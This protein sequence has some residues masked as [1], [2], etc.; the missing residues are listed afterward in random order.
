MEKLF[1]YQVCQFLP[2]KKIFK[3]GLLK[4]FVREVSAYVCVHPWGKL[5]MWSE[6]VLAN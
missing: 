4:F 1:V 2:D 6:A 3:A 5:L